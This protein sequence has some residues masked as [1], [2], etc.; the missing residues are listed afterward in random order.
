[1]NSDYIVLIPARN[2]SK[3]LPNKNIKLLN[4]KPLFMY[5]VEQGLKFSNRVIISTNIPQILNMQPIEGVEI[6]KRSEAIAQDIS[7]MDEV[8]HDL[9]LSKNLMEMNLILLQPT[10]PLR[11]SYDI[12]ESI[13]I[14]EK[15]NF[16]VLFT[17]T[18][19]NKSILKSGFTEG[20]KFFPIS[21]PE[22]CFTNRQSLPEVYKP[23]GAIYIFKAN[24]F[25]EKSKIPSA[26]MGTFTMPE[27]R[28][29]DI[30]ND[31]DFKKAEMII[32][33]L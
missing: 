26:N 23:N 12:L 2:G 13:N 3:G 28:S 20:N 14:F 15:N 25:L 29:I 30:D 6:H 5:A 19:E 27:D 8:I 24:K 1:M 4:G 9:I 10:S 32:R 21:N 11:T 7:T 16:D 31:D 33:A 22:Y 17:S 18:F